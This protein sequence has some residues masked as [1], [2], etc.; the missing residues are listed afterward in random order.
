MEEINELRKANYLGEMLTDKGRAV[1]K[2]AALLLFFAALSVLCYFTVT[3]GAERFMLVNETAGIFN[4]VVTTG[5][6]NEI[7]NA[8]KLYNAANLSFIL[9][10]AGFAAFI[11][12]LFPASN[13]RGPQ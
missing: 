3:F 8:L 6:A 7:E 5:F 11:A 10:A 4:G 12:A 9:F 13:R 2:F 1:Y